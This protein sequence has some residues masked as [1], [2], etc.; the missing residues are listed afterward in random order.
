MG[1]VLRLWVVKGSAEGGSMGLWVGS[2]RNWGFIDNGELGIM[3]AEVFLWSEH[4]F[5]GQGGN[6]TAFLTVVHWSWLTIAIV[7]ILLIMII[8]DN[9]GC[10]GRFLSVYCAS[11]LPPACKEWPG[12]PS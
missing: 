9:L 11:E 4:L 3:W 5:R 1:G 7:R 8:D 6:V 2:R 12:L 10:A